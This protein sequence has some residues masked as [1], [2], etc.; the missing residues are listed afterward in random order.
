M[1]LSIITS[2]ARV[3]TESLP[4]VE[5]LRIDAGCPSLA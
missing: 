3:V 5:Y 4:Q 2:V 1:L